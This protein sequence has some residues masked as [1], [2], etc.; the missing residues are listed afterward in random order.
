MGRSLGKTSAKLSSKES[1]ALG[2]TLL[3]S[4]ITGEATSAHTTSVSRKCFSNSA[5]GRVRRVR[6]G[7]AGVGDEVLVAGNSSTADGSG[8]GSNVIVRPLNSKL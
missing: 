8:D 3:G 7:V 1:N 5:L 2:T 4:D 6:A